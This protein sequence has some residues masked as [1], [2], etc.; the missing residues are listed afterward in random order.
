MKVEFN[1]P[2]PVGLSLKINGQDYSLLAITPHDKQDG[3]K[4]TLLVWLS[5]CSV[6]GEDFEFRSPGRSLPENRRCCS[7]RRPGVRDKS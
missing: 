2:P 3:T 1:T 5:Q 6:C 7:H 4:T